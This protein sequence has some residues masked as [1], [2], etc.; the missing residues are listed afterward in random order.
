MQVYTD[1]FVR[2]LANLTMDRGNGSPGT[3]NHDSN[4]AARLLV[5]QRDYWYKREPR[6]KLFISLCVS[7]SIIRTRTCIPG[8]YISLARPR[9]A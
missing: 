4:K 3:H 2:R 8:R 5:R 7:Y 6:T 9:I 1:G